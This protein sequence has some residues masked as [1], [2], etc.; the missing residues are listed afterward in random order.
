M[1]EFV[2]AP[3]KESERESEREKERK[4]EKY[5]FIYD[6][7]DHAGFFLYYFSLLIPRL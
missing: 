4:R 1:E 6:T 3:E 5:N 2:G 7:Y